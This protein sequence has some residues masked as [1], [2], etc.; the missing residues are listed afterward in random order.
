M[1]SGPVLFATALGMRYNR[2]GIS[3]LPARRQDSMGCG[4]GCFFDDMCNCMLGFTGQKY[5]DLYTSQSVRAEMRSQAALICRPMS[6]EFAPE[7]TR[8]DEN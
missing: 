5:Q 6:D 7:K 1:N 3:I 4:I 8:S 2:A